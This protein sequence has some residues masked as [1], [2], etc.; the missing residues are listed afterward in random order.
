MIRRPSA[1][2][3]VVGS[4]ETAGPAEPVAFSAAVMSGVHLDVE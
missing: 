3:S 4:S 2:P 1:L